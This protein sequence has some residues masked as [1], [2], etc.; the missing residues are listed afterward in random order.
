MGEHIDED[1]GFSL[2]IYARGLQGRV[3][4]MKSRRNTLRPESIEGDGMATEN[5]KHA[6]IA[7]RVTDLLGF[8]KEENKGGFVSHQNPTP[9]RTSR[10]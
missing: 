7:S 9:I 8:V 4:I 2:A 10:G 3:V 5:G 1:D 6:P